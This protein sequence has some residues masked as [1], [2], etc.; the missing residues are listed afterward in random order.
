MFS[1]N[2]IDSMYETIKASGVDGTLVVDA[3]TMEI[4]NGF[5]GIQVF[6]SVSDS[7]SK[8]KARIE[9]ALNN[10]YRR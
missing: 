7:E 4:N 6:F 1:Q 2:L 9:L 3:E 10:Y 5:N 8:N